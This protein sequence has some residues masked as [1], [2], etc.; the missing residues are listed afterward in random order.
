MYFYIDFPVQ[1][2]YPII[3]DRAVDTC[4]D[5]S[6]GELLRRLPF[7]FAMKDGAIMEVEVIEKSCAKPFLTYDELIEK[8]KEKGLCVPDKMRAIELLK[9]HSYFGLINGYKKPFKASKFGRYKKG[10]TIDDIYSLYK[11]DD[12]TRFVLLKNII[13]VEKRIKSLISY[14]FCTEFGERQDQYLNPNN[15]N[16]TSK[17]KD[18]VLKLTDILKEIVT[19]PF[20]SSYIKHQFN[21][22]NNVPL[23]V[24]IKA[25]TFG[26]IS[27]MYSCLPFK[28]KFMIVKEFPGVDEGALENMLNLLTRFRNVCAHSERLFDYKYNKASI[29]DTWVHEQLGI[30]RGNSGYKQGRNDF[31]ACLICLKYL[32]KE[33]HFQELIKEIEHH[34]EKLFNSTNQIQESMLRK[35][36]GLPVNWRQIKDISLN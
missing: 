31:F 9:D 24:A 15:Y 30:P 34:L 11:F 1:P 14:C 3:S 29:T 10:A 26:N 23:W 12:K 20:T 28:V 7:H 35:L 5:Y 2:C 33:R 25:L 19:P 6:L 18:D 16:I 17:N 8:L 13:L 36:M 32:L 22:Y 21:K 27:K 4:E